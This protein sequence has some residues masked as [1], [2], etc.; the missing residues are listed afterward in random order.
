MRRVFTQYFTDAEQ[1]NISLIEWGKTPGWDE[2]WG[3][4]EEDERYD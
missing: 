4:V 1:G 2:D 3:I